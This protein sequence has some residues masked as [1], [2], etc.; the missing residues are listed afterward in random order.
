LKKKRLGP[1]AF[2]IVKFFRTTNPFK[3]GD[4]VHQKFLEHLMFYIC[5]DY[6]PF[7]HL[8]EYLAVNVNELHAKV[9]VFIFLLYLFWW[10]KYFMY[11][12]HKIYKPS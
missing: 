10:K 3:K 6:R 11:N 5:K 7:L 8:Q 9:V 12:V 4:E 2:A 1:S